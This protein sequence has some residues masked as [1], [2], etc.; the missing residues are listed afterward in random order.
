MTIKLTKGLNHQLLHGVGLLWVLYWIQVLKT[1]L[2]SATESAIL[3]GKWGGWG[4][5]VGGDH[6]GD[7][8]ATV[9]DTLQRPMSKTLG[10]KLG[11]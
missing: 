2:E 7:C 5:G 11:Y 1:K 8:G 4:W 3:C 10:M 9:I 6:N